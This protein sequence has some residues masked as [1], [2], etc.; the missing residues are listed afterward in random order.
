MNDFHR[1]APAMVVFFAGSL[2]VP[3]GFGAV[4]IKGGSPVTPDTYGPIVHAVPALC[5]V[6]VQLAISIVAVVGALRKMPTVTAIGAG[7]V[8]FLMA[9][10][11]GAAILA[12]A[13][14][15][16]LVFG[17]GGWVA[18]V[19]FVAAAVAWRGRNGRR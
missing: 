2:S 8:G 12:G 11:A 13:S 15:T 17:A 6:G 18:P 7:L 4:V 3:I 10:F 14:G 16:I 19:S 9:F 5:W 1:Y